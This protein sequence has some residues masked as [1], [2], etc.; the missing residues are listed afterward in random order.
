MKRCPTCQRTYESDT[1]LYCFDDGTLLQSTPDTRKPSGDLQ[2]TI[3]YEKRN[4]T[5]KDRGQEQKTITSIRPPVDEHQ[6][7]RRG[8]GHDGR[9]RRH[10]WPWIVG[11]IAAIVLVVVGGI[12]ILIYIGAHRYNGN[13][14]NPSPTPI[15]P[16]PT[17]ITNATVSS[18]PPKKA[19]FSKWWVG[20]DSN[21]S[22]WYQ[23]GE[24]HG[25]AVPSRWVTKYSPLQAPYSTK[26]ATITLTTRAVDGTSPVYGYGLVVHSQQMG[27]KYR[28][29]SFLIKSDDNPSYAIV[30]NMGADQTY[31]RDWTRSAV[32]KTGATPNQ[33]QVVTNDSTLTF[34][35]NGNNVDSIPDSAGLRTGRVGVYL[36][37]TSEVAFANLSIKH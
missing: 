17:P 11:I 26:D 23:N 18:A 29:Y 1:Q 34:N 3:A 5:G 24:Y 10:V 21:S 35:I 16:S 31:V 27:K 33:L 8:Q 6:W 30:M 13:V 32:I 2:E 28:D 14:N 4:V 22:F 7:N 15:T 37:G 9:P 25:K 36:S 19:D 12:A 20:T